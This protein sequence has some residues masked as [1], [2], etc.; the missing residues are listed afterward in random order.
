MLLVEHEMSL[1]FKY[2]PARQFYIVI[3]ASELEARELPAVFI[4]IFRRKGKI[5]CQTLEL[6]KLNQKIA[7][8]H[9]EVIMMS[10]RSIHD[11]IND[12][13]TEV[14]PLFRIS[15]SIAMLDMIASF[16]QLV[17]TQD[18][19]RPELT[20]TLAIKAGRHP[21][22]EKIQ[23]EKYIP[24]DVYATQQSRLQI[25]TGC[26]MS[27]KST[28]IRTVALMAIIAQI[29]CFV[30][31]QYSSFPMTHQL[32]A[33]ISTDDSIEA[34]VSTFAAEMREIA[35]ILRNV[36]RRSLVIVD[37]LGRGTS[38]ADGLA[39]ATAIAEALLESRAYIWFVTHFRDLPR[40]LQERRGVVNL[41]LAVDIAP[42]SS[43][44]KMLYKISDGYEQEKF[45]GIVLAKVVDLPG[46][47]IAVATEVSNALHERNEARRSTK[48]FLAVARR[49]KLI[50]S[51]REQLIQA[52][53]GLL[54]GEELRHWLNRLQNEL[55]VRMAAIDAEAAQVAT[56]AKDAEG[57]DGAG[58]LGAPTS[59]T[60][61]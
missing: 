45:Y 38:T 8:A 22:K 34:N 53:N 32:F 44:M 21:V 47:V 13:R 43:K 56:E 20:E 30:P 29:G 58:S 18:Y 24:N 37:E 41:H 27:G 14:Q 16:A 55:I 15:E 6:V 33:R 26:N 36:E 60:S 17:T 28:Y 42:D 49:R 9:N 4:N 25:I 52:K 59:T 35:F 46:D 12:V 40:I 3:P 2:D 57:S 10:D 31:A 48:A 11:L 39:V 19:V 7:D 50:L 23:R 51:L 61:E 1:D 5:E 54:E